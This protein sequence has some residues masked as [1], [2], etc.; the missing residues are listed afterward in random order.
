MDDLGVP[1]IV[2]TPKLIKSEALV[3]LG[4]SHETKSA[5]WRQRACQACPSEMTNCPRTLHLPPGRCPSHKSLATHHAE[6]THHSGLPD[7]K[8]HANRHV[9]RTYWIETSHTPCFLFERQ[10]PQG[11]KQHAKSDLHTGVRSVYIP[12]LCWLKQLQNRNPIC[13]SFSECATRSYIINHS[14][15]DSHTNNLWN[16]NESSF[17]RAQWNELLSNWHCR[18]MTSMKM[19]GLHSLWWSTSDWRGTPPK[20]NCSKSHR[21]RPSALPRGQKPLKTSSIS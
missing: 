1:P 19:H 3:S 2:E 14:R 5:C 21:V 12:N 10:W 15:A 8:T 16:G 4:K 9:Y 18:N 6:L 20:R 11:V 7:Q 13:S 17:F